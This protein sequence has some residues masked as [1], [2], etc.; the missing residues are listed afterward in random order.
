MVA[1]AAVLIMQMPGDDIV[2]MFAVRNGLVTAA[3]AVLMAAFMFSAF[4]LIA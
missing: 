2:R 3:F 1:M 4:M